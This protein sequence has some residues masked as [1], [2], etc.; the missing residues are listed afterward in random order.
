MD[1]MAPVLYRLIYTCG[2][3]PREGRELKTENINLKTGEI[4]IV[5]TKK[6]QARCNVK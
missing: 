2:L 5:Q 6:G 1:E 4:L 3:R